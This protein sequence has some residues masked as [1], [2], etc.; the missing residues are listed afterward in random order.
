[1]LGHLSGN[2][3]SAVVW[4]GSEI[5][6]KQEYGEAIQAGNRFYLPAPS[7]VNQ[8][9]RYQNFSKMTEK[10]Q[11]RVK[12]KIGSKKDRKVKKLPRATGVRSETSLN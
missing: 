10:S 7:R 2:A 12:S 11:I 6:I 1:M 8:G 3:K 5:R 9:D 4:S